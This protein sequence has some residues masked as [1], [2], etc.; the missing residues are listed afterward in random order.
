[1]EDN[2]SQKEQCIHLKPQGHI[3]VIVTLT[4]SQFPWEQHG[5]F[6]EREIRKQIVSSDGG[7]PLH[8]PKLCQKLQGQVCDS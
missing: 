6:E 2:C 8:E 7:C 3:S 1:M 5:N 4:K